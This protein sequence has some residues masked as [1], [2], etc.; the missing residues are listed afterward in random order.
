MNTLSRVTL[1]AVAIGAYGLFNSVHEVVSPLISGPMAA[2]QL[3]DSNAAYVGTQVTSRLF[4]GS[5]IDG[6]WL[7][8]LVVV[9]LVGIWYH[10]VANLLCTIHDAK[11]D[12]N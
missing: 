6:T 2:Q 12:R 8:L 1:S 7:S 4:N 11:R 9:V 10:P 5:G 3:S